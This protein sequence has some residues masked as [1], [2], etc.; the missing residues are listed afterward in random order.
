MSRCITYVADVIFFIGRITF[1][2]NVSNFLQYQRSEILW[3]QMQYLPIIGRMKDL[4]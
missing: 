2:N 4:F 1:I 3:E